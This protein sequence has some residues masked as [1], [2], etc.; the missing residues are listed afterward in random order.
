M[1][2]SASITA[3]PEAVWMPSGWIFDDALERL[4]VAVPAEAEMLEET[5]ASNGALALDLRALPAERF[6]ALA[7][8]ARAAVRD[9]IDA[10][11]EP[12]EDP[13]WFAPQVYGLSLFAGLLNADP[14][15][16]EEPPAGQIE[17][18]PGA[19]WHAPGRAYALIAEHLAGDIRPTSGLLAGSLLHGDAD[20][21]RL[22]E[23]RFRAFLPGLDFMATRYVPGANLD[24]FADAF[25]A[26]IAPH[27]A[28]LR[29]LFAADPRTAARSR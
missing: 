18:A 27:V 13:S 15:A 26:E 19:V 7:T 5:I 6:A 10:G 2:G 14:R 20:L 21:G 4:A 25:F 28:A 22:D 9:V 17:V 23:D 16:G 29:D 1:S 3:A 12:G 11:P 8:A 24:A